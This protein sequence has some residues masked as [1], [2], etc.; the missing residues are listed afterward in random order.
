MAEFYF[1]TAK[2]IVTGRREGGSV[3]RISWRPERRRCPD[4]YD[5]ETMRGSPRSLGALGC[6]NVLSFA[7]AR[8][9]AGQRTRGGICDFRAGITPSTSPK[10][11]PGSFICQKRVVFFFFGN[12]D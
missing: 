2:A 12:L 6:L 10:S 7:V 3:D 4:I 9:A 5:R 8:R 11:H 1:Y